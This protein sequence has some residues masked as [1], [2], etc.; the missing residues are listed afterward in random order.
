MFDRPEFASPVDTHLDL[1]DDEQDAVLIQNLLEFGEEVHGRNDIATGA[2]DR[3]DIEGGIFCAA[4][5]RIPD[6]VI[7]AFE[8][9]SEFAHAMFAIFLLG[10]ALPAAEMV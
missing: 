3:F 5:L 10:H 8:E 6:A 2:L 4:D 9:A 1:V 7:F